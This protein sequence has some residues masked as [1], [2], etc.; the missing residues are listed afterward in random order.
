MRTAPKP[1][2]PRRFFTVTHP[3]HPWRGR[4]FEWVDLRRAWGQWRVFYLVTEREI[5][6]MPASWTDVGPSDPFVEQAQGRS[7]ARVEDLLALVKMTR[8]ECK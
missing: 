4:R 5:A 2:E 1:N 6:S 3:F 7:L 8:K